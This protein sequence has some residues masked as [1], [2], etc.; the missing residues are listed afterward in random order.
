M[1][2]GNKRICY[3]CGAKF[4]DLGKDPASCPKCETENYLDGDPR[5]KRGRKQLVEAV[6]D[7]KLDDI[8]VEIDDMEE[9]EE[10]DHD[11][12]VDLGVD[13]RD[14]IVAKDEDE[15]ARDR[16]NEDGDVLDEVEDEDEDEEDDS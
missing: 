6:D 16:A 12:D 15:E 10:I 11:D 2:L 4:Y 14:K 1:A 5:T 8:E 9:L 13:I 3:S 7:D